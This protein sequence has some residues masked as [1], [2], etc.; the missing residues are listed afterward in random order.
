LSRNPKSDGQEPNP[1]HDAGPDQLW[2]VDAEGGAL[3]VAQGSAANVD[4]GALVADNLVLD[5]GAGLES[6]AHAYDG[7][8]P[9]ALDGHELASVDATL[10]MLASSP[11]LFDVPA[12]E[13]PP[14]R[15]THL[16]ARAR[17]S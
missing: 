15:T 17:S 7:H 6:A 11:D 13:C 12:L 9:M 4:A 10:D 5:A 3:L 2:S 1:T 14:P 16:R 8:V